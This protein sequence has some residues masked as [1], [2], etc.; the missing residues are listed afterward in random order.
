MKKE[1]VYDEHIAPLMS[2]IID[3]CKQN[4]IAAFAHFRLDNK[5]DEDQVLCTTALPVSNN[6][7]DSKVINKL[8]NVVMNN[9]DVVPNTWSMTITD[10]KK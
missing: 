4:D 10:N 5:D 7:K 1:K 9:W 3:L 2:Q 6:S 8:K